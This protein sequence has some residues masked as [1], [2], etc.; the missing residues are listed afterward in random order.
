MSARDDVHPPRGARW[1]LRLAFQAY[2]SWVMDRCNGLSAAMAFFSFAALPGSIVVVFAGAHTFLADETARQVIVEW[3]GPRTYFVR[4]FL[5]EAK[6]MSP[7]ELRQIGLVGLFAFVYGAVG[8]FACIKD[9]MET[10]WDVRREE[11]GFVARIRRVGRSLLV[12]VGVQLIVVGTVAARSI[13][14]VLKQSPQVQALPWRGFLLL[15]AVEGLIAFCFLFALTLFYF[16]F[17]SPVR[18]RWRYVWPGA[19]ATAL[20]LMLVRPLAAHMMQSEGWV[21]M[22]GTAGSLIAVLIWFYVFGALLLYGAELTRHY[23]ELHDAGLHHRREAAAAAAVRREAAYE[24]M[25]QRARKAAHSAFA[26]RKS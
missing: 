13:L 14:P 10:V 7:A 15:G 8:Y 6:K 25:M 3:L 11:F 5:V 26:R 19:A 9:A 24:Q 1:W 12:T 17:L 21:G 22:L 23:I 16:K 18:Q 20:L 2:R 4:A